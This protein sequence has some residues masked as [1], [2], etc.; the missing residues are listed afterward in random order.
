MSTLRKYIFRR[1]SLIGNIP[2]PPSGGGPSPIIIDGITY[3]EVV[4]PYTGRVW[5]D[6]NLGATQVATSISDSDGYGGLYQWGRLTDGHQLRNSTAVYGTQAT[7]YANAGTN[8]ISNSGGDWLTPSN[9]NLWNTL[10]TE[11]F[12]NGYSVPTE[13]EWEAEELGIRNEFGTSNL[14]TWNNSFLKISGGG[15][16]VFDNPT[17]EG[18]YGAYWTREAS[19][20]ANARSLVLYND[21]GNVAGALKSTGHS[22]RLIKDVS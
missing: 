14:T 3:T 21:A 20:N 10:N 13:A 15:Y 17:S 6:R 4:S 16:R 5:L 22:V 8:F 2:N 19:S 9:N 7:D 11:D 12:P 18:N 1:N